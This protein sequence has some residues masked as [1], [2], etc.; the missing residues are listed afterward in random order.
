MSP[1]G[2][3][4]DEEREMFY[5]ID[6]DIPAPKNVPAEEWEEMDDVARAFYL[7]EGKFL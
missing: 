7:F 3:W 2:S 4:N 5:E 1:D 6:T